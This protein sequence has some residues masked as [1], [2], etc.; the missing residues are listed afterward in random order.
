VKDRKRGII[1]KDLI[2][3]N[4]NEPKYGTQITGVNK[5]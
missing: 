1:P 5:K 2:F 3:P 4:E